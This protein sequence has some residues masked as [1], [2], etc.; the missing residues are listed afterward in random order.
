MA[1]T[2]SGLTD[3]HTDR[4]THR[5]TDAGNDN[6]RR[7]KL[8]S[9]KNGFSVS[10]H[11]MHQWKIIVDWPIRNERKWNINPNLK[12]ACP[13]SAL[14]KIILDIS[15]KLYTRRTTEFPVGVSG[16]LIPWDKFH[17]GYMWCGCNRAKLIAFFSLS[18]LEHRIFFVAFA[19]YH[20]CRTN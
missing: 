14:E 16:L 13:E 18:K 4:H 19:V 9:G 11:Y 2:S 12:L 17:F 1:R 7:P 20:F 15:D 10:N 6:T 5:Q 8:A 3:T